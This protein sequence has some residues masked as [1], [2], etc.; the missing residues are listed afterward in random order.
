M[1]FR[2]RKITSM[3]IC[4]VVV[5]LVCS[6]AVAAENMLGDVDSDGEVT[7]IDA[8]AI[9]RKLS[10]LHVSSFSE[11]AAD[12]D[13]SGEIEITDATFIQRWVAK[14]ETPYLI[15]VLP[16]QQATEPPTQ[17]STD[18]EGW[19]RDIFQP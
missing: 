15:G 1:T 2:L 19:G 7:L 14:I 3:L 17:R 16:T 10:G 5:M 18:D 13:S 8:T 11:S 12:V 4:V 6:V 9:Q